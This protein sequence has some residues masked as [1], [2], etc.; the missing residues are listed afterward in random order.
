M[1]EFFVRV[2]WL[3]GLV[4][5]PPALSPEPTASGS[6]LIGLVGV[7]VILV[8]ALLVYRF[9]RH[10]F[11]FES[12]LAAVLDAAALVALLVGAQNSSKPLL[13]AYY[14]VA[15]FVWAALASTLATLAGA[16]L[17]S[18]FKNKR[19]GAAILTIA[20]GLFSFRDSATLIASEAEQ[21]RSLLARA[22][23]NPRALEAL[24]DE[25]EG[26]PRSEPLTAACVAAEPNHCYCRTV[27]AETALSRDRF[28]SALEELAQASGCDGT[29]DRRI[30]RAKALAFALGKRTDEADAALQA[31]GAGDDGWISYAA[32]LTASQRGDSV[33]ALQHATRAVELGAGRGAE[34]LLA[35][36]Q[37]IAGQLEP[38]GVLLDRLIASNPN[39]ADAVYNRALVFD[40]TGNY[41][42]SRQAYLRAL[43]I[44]P[45]SPDARY[46]LALLTLRYGARAE[47]EHHARKFAESWPNDPRGQALQAR[48]GSGP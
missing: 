45:N 19:M 29:Q 44:R 31:W 23:A 8:L 24:K 39:D 26:G 48:I 5:Y 41:N 17:G 6:V 10:Y 46:N 2:A 16:H 37:I 32:A 15:P 12:K 3:L 47:A 35:A 30:N 36:L 14:G 40:R 9:A 25:V 13:S 7:A 20:L 21:W 42:E 1:I 18:N 33:A 34:L 11:G 28:A 22:P 4:L 43:A 27:R 38:A